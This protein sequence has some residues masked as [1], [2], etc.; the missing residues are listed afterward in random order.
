MENKKSLFSCLAKFFGSDAE[1]NNDC[2][3]E[4]EGQQFTYLTMDGE[5]IMD[6]KDPYTVNDSRNPSK[7]ILS[8]S[9]EPN[10]L[11]KMSFFHHLDERQ[12]IASCGFQYIGSRPD[13]KYFPESKTSIWDI[14]EKVEDYSGDCSKFKFVISRSPHDTPRHMHLRYGNDL[15]ALLNMSNDEEDEQYNPWWSEYKEVL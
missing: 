14:F 8:T 13:P 6:P 9:E 7:I 11:T 1:Q 3:K 4:E 10:S 2:K 12:E 15:E 5:F